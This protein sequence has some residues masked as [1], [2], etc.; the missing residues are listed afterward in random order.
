MIALISPVL[1]FML[2]WVCKKAITKSDI[3]KEFNEELKSLRESCLLWRTK[4]YEVKHQE[5]QKPSWYNVLFQVR[6]KGILMRSESVQF[7]DL[8]VPIYTL[9]S[10]YLLVNIIHIKNMEKRNE[11]TFDMVRN[12]LFNAGY[13]K[14]HPLTDEAFEDAFPFSIESQESIK[15]GKLFTIDNIERGHV[16]DAQD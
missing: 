5:P 6:M 16:S 4:F 2:G 15:V 1:G 8:G 11:V 7:T 14:D 10:D 12:A 3:A 9:L 13:H